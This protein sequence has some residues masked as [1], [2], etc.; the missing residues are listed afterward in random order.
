MRRVVGVVALVVAVLVPAPTAGASTLNAATAAPAPSVLAVSATPSAL[1]FH[2]G[3]VTVNGR[4]R[5][6]ATC[7]QRLL[8]HQNFVVVFATNSRPCSSM[9]SAHVTIGANPTTVPRTVAFELIARK[10][11]KSPAR[12]FFITVG[13]GPVLHGTRAARRSSGGALGHQDTF[14]RA[15][16]ALGAGWAD[17]TGGG[18]AIV[19][20]E[21]T[22]TNSS[23]TSGDI[24]TGEAYGSDQYS[25]VQVTSTPLS[26]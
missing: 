16:G 17:M 13:P 20:Q 11:N 12:R 2:G 6:A 14:A 15:D 4:V 21:V 23:G 5:N 19:N 26:G 25:E 3:T 8:S 7:Q 9:F 18:L 10:G 1:S 22:G 24:R